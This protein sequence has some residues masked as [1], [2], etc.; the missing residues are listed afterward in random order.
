MIGHIKD[1]IL[2]TYG[3]VR[4][5]K[6]AAVLQRIGYT[7]LRVAGEAL[8]AIRAIKGKTDGIFSDFF[9]LPQSVFEKVRTGM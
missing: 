6:D 1:G 4:D 5:L 2:I 3:I 7:N 9:Y 8:I